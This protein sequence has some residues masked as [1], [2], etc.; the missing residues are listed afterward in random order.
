MTTSVIEPES[1]TPDQVVAAMKKWIVECG[2]EEMRARFQVGRLEMKEVLDDVRRVLF[3]RLEV[4]PRFKHMGAREVCD[5]RCG[6]NGV[7]TFDVYE[8][9]TLIEPQWSRL[10]RISELA[11]PDAGMIV[12]IHQGSCD[13]CG[14][15]RSRYGVLVR[16]A[17]ESWTLQREYAL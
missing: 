8:G 13:G 7:V 12:R 11:P 10:R 16:V 2:N 9:E 1:V 15:S 6:C 3:A 14:C 5:Q 17:W 4:V